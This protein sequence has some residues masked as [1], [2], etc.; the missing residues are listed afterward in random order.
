VNRSITTPPPNGCCLNPAEAAQCSFNAVPPQVFQDGCVDKLQQ[1][2]KNIGILLGAIAIAIGI[3]EVHTHSAYGGV[4]RH[5]EL[6]AIP[7]LHRL[8]CF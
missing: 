7:S 6:L 1:L 5:L 8:R 2:L 4:T 3:V